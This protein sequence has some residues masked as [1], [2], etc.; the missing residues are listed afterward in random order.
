MLI[1]N[2]FL[3]LPELL[4]SSYEQKGNVEALIVNYMVTG[5]QMELACRSVPFAYNHVAV[6]KPYPGQRRKGTIYRVDLFFDSEGTVPAVSHLEQYGL[7]KNNWIEAKSFFGGK[8]TSP[9]KTQNNGRII[10]DI[11]RLCLFPE[12]LQGK[13]R[14]NARYILLIFDQPPSAYLAY[15]QRN[16]LKSIIEDKTPNIEIDLST[17]PKSCIKSIVKSDSINA[18]IKIK[19]SKLSFEPITSTPF[20]VYWGQLLRIDEFFISINDR[21]IHYREELSDHW[22]KARIDNLNSVKSEFIGMLLADESDII[23]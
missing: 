4:L 10:K 20:P 13:H 8:K 16:W 14:E 6:E 22:D 19:L 3:K 17:E 12:E 1:E 9:A 11:L 5:I 23:G 21:S 15:S 7:K 18:Q 2:A